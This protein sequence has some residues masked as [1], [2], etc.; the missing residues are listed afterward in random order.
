MTG[1]RRQPNPCGNMNHR[2]ANAPVGHCPWC[3]GVVNAAVRTDAC[4][5][6]HHALGRRRHTVFCVHCGIRLIVTR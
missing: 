3:G 1:S 2:R 4:T 6:E 5:E